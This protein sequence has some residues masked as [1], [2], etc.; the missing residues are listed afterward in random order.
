MVNK[1]AVSISKPKTKRIRQNKNLITE[2]MLYGEYNAFLKNKTYINM[3]GTLYDDMFAGM[4][5]RLGWM[6]WLSEAKNATREGLAG[7]LVY[8]TKDR[9]GAS[10]KEMQKELAANLIKAV[11][12]TDN[13]ADYIDIKKIKTW[14]S[15][16]K[17]YASTLLKTKPSVYE[18]QQLAKAFAP[19]DKKKQEQIVKNIQYFSAHD[20]EIEKAAKVFKVAGKTLGV[21][22]VV[23]SAYVIQETDSELVDKLYGLVDHSSDLGKG[24]RLIKADQDKGFTITF[25]RNFINKVLIEGELASKI[26]DDLIIKQTLM[27]M[28]KEKIVSES[29][30][31]AFGAAEAF[32]WGVSYLMPGKKADDVVEAW[33][34]L[35]NA[36]TLSAACSNYRSA[37]AKNWDNGGPKTYEEMRSDY[38]LLIEAYKCSLVSGAEKVIDCAPSKEKKKIREDLSKY[39]NKIGYEK[40]IQSCLKNANTSYSVTQKR[41]ESEDGMSRG[42][43]I[44]EV[45]IPNSISEEDYI[46]I[47]DEIDG[48][49][50]VGIGNGVF[51]RRTDITAVTLPE[52]LLTIDSDG[53]NECTSL[54]TVY[55]GSNIQRIG[56]RAF[57]GCKSLENI[58]IPDSTNEIGLK[59]LDTGIETTIEGA[60][61]LEADKYADENNLL[62]VERGRK[63][64]SIEVIEGPNKTQY[65][66]D[67]SV[68]KTGI[69]IKATY[70]DGTEEIITEGIAVWHDSFVPGSNSITIAYGDCT[71]SADVTVTEENCQYTIFYVDEY[72]EEIAEEDKGTAAGGSTVVTRAKSIEGYRPYETT[73]ELT[74]GADNRISFVYFKDS[75][76]DISN[77]KIQIGDSFQY[78]G[79]Q[80]KPNVRITL[81]N[82]ALEEG[83]DYELYFGDNVKDNGYVIIEG[84]G[85]YEGIIIKD[86]NI[87]SSNDKHVRSISLSAK[88][89]VN[90][91]AGKK[92]TITAIIAPNNAANKNVSWTSS[93]GKYATVNAKG[94]VTTKKAGKGK[95]VVITATAKD[96]SGVKSRIKINLKK[97]VVK[98]I[99]VKGK[100]TVKAGKST[101]VKSTVRA[102][103]GANK[104]VMWTSSNS[105]YATVN[106]KGVVKTKKTAKGKTVKITAIATDGSG[107]KASIRIKI[108]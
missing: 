91:S 65:R 17:K 100:K 21:A 4:A 3:V 29:I 15:L 73:Q 101:K 57:R 87:V 72:G 93:N 70:A 83:T 48:M 38:S 42:V 102:T 69:K 75:D 76:N 27:A 32:W 55:F 103:K 89:S 58:D 68:D 107:K 96:G 95:S 35:A 50:V 13:L 78:S 16:Q 61:G 84:K 23:I 5:N 88:P 26:V 39:K 2:E 18:A 49:P 60:K 108:K 97:G 80:I 22:D 33:E 45:Y 79:R 24:L 11:G 92:V 7:S 30:S 12:E 53:F 85:D 106:A 74:I 51:M 59:A 105:K 63:P 41:V 6:D 40:Y 98:K 1:R 64:V 86:F 14:N 25:V 46:D 90:I 54:D 36:R 77:A 62:F 31:G 52:A 10:E 44:D 34:H 37:I 71:S 43:V 82:S 66:V 67:E 20:K 104:K 81:G 94:V 56:D 28:S 8:I 99:S 9:I 47:P 19:E